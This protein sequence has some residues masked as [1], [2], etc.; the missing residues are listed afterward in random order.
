MSTLSAYF[1]TCT[2]LIFVTLLQTLKSYSQCPAPAI[3]GDRAAMCP[4]QVREWTALGVPNGSTVYWKKNG[5]QFSTG[6]NAII[7]G[8][9]NYSVFY[10]TSSCISPEATEV[11]QPSSSCTAP[12]VTGNGTGL[13]GNYFNN[14]SLSGISIERID[15]QIN[16]DFGNGQN[17]PFG[18]SVNNFSVR[19][20]GEIQ[21]PTDGNFTFY[22]TTD[23]GLRLWVNGQQLI[24][25][26]IPQ[27]A[28]E[29]VSTITMSRGIKY[30]IKI[31]YYQ[32]AGDAIARLHWSYPN[33]SKQFIPT[34][35]LYPAA[36]TN[37]PPPAG[38]SGTGLTASYF[39]NVNLS[40]LP[41]FT[42]TDSQVDFPWVNGGPGSG[43]GP[44][45]FSVRWEGQV[46]APASGTFYFRTNN[47]DGTRLWVNGQLLI[48]D[49][50]AHAPTWRQG[51]LSL[52][53]GQKV[54]I[55]LEFYEAGG[56]AQCKLYWEYP[57]QGQQIVPTQYLYPSGTTNPP[58]PSSNFIHPS[59]LVGRST[60]TISNCDNNDCAFGS[61]PGGST[62]GARLVTPSLEPINFAPENRFWEPPR[63]TLE[64]YRSIVA[65]GFA[66]DPVESPFDNQYSQQFFSGSPDYNEV[67]GWMLAYKDLGF[68]R[69]DGS[70]I[71]RG[72]PFFALYNRYTGIL[73]MF[74][75]NRP[76]D[77][78]STD[79][80]FAMW[81]LR[82][83]NWNC[84]YDAIDSKR[85]GL[86]AVAA[87]DPNFLYIDDYN[88]DLTDNAC[89]PV[90]QINFS[91]STIRWI[92]TDF[93]LTGYDPNN[94]KTVFELTTQPFSKDSITADIR[95]KLQAQGTI[96]S[97][98]DGKDGIKTIG[99]A[100]KN[101]SDVF[102]GDDSSA[103]FVKSL[104]KVGKVLSAAS[105]SAALFKFA[106]GI[107]GAASAPDE[108]VKRINIS[109]DVSGKILGSVTRR[110]QEINKI[111]LGIT[112]DLPYDSESGLYRPVQDISWGVF[113]LRRLPNLN[114][115][116]HCGGASNGMGGYTKSI[117]LHFNFGNHLILNPSV[118]NSDPIKGMTLQ[119]SDI[120]LIYDS[121]NTSDFQPINNANF[122][123]FTADVPANSNVFV[124]PPQLPTAIILKLVF[125][126]NASGKEVILT[127]SYPISTSRSIGE[128]HAAVQA[129]FFAPNSECEGFVGGGRI[130]A[131]VFNKLYEIEAPHPN[132]FSENITIP[133]PAQRGEK[134]T[135]TVYSMAGQSLWAFQSKAH[136]GQTNLQWNG[137]DR[138]GH[139]LP[140]GIYLIETYLSEQ[141]YR[142]KKVVLQR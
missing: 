96:T 23:D 4:D 60:R 80:G 9:G 94:K 142:R 126:I 46:E 98:A 103:K 83:W 32:G 8:P 86:M 50:V 77:R 92:T 38:G 81:R 58:P 15:P 59:V 69:P 117:Y 62:D 114:F 110:G 125:T 108:S 2:F 102:G 88:S 6:S 129:K 106:I 48:D 55:K 139:R 65:G 7:N 74:Q 89:N 100:F 14:V 122:N 95:A 19:W 101:I 123:V 33:Q 51:Q 109:G 120:A 128:L 71:G 66:F 44:D 67:N 137:V 53:A 11:V 132:P 34:Q 13:R 37:P 87:T 93:I 107:F 119:A 118:V 27:G 78:I 16:F 85:T 134:F 90:Q 35:Y 21:S 111:Y 99:E 30:S 12:G 18:V 29:Y 3:G 47:D 31:E 75:L 112:N 79:M 17:V 82:Q 64:I 72:M 39:N 45:N 73:R 63:R 68:R 138:A 115:E 104:L 42:R 84:G 136:E 22:G 116:L 20:E 49:W 10:S 61:L 105:S 121:G 140:N 76:Q 113:N 135:V 36:T 131:E 133:I 56:G 40:G 24:N 70:V 43:V 52:F 5:Q 57:N 1:R 41:T 124:P 28:T 141:G 54:A 127:K 91:L 130:A 26:W 97:E 25:S